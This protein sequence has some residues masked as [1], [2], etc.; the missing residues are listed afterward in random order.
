L[1]QPQQSNA[2]SP[3]NPQQPPLNNGTNRSQTAYNKQG[4]DILPQPNNVQHVQVEKVLEEW[5]KTPGKHQPAVETCQFAKGMGD[6]WYLEKDRGVF[7]GE[8]RKAELGKT[9]GEGA[10]KGR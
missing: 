6:R 2:T 10:M 3:A 4:P 1:S 8:R 9:A 7:Q 5:P